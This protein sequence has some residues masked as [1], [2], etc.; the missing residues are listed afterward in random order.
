MDRLESLRREIDLIDSE[1][2]RLLDRR[3]EIAREIGRIKLDRGLD[4]HDPDREGEIL[5][6]IGRYREIYREIFNYSKKEQ[7]NIFS[8]AKSKINYRIGVIGYGKMGRLFTKIF[9]KY[10]KEVSIYDVRDIEEALEDVVKTESLEELIESSDLIMVST[11]LTT[12][13]ETL[14]ELRELVVKKNVEGKTIFDIATIK[15]RVV[16]ELMKFPDNIDVATVHPMF[17]P[18][19]E[20]HIGEKIFVMGIPGREESIGRISEIFRRIGFKTIETDYITHDLYMI[21]TIGIPYLLGYSYEKVLEPLGGD[22]EIFGGPS[23]K[24]FKEYYR[25]ISSDGE[26]FIRYILRHPRGREAIEKLVDILWSTSGLGDV[27]P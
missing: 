8:N 17:G 13:H 27:N 5:N 6:R 26:E 7:M 15:Y 23:Y 12:I 11:P 3:F 4:I 14:R 22:V 21:Y 10:F 19:I 16:H 9:K 18:N 24:T 25:R 2:I 20:S 1:I